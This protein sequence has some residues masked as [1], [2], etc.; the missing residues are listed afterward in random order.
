[1]KDDLNPGQLAGSRDAL[2]EALESLRSK[3]P[4][5]TGSRSTVTSSFKSP[6]SGPCPDLVYWF[7]LATGT[8][9]ANEKEAL[10][11]HASVCSACLAQL[12]QCQE[13]LSP[14]S[15]PEEWQEFKDFASATPQWQHRLAVELAR[16]PHQAQRSART[17]RIFAW[18]AAAVAAVLLI[19]AAVTVWWRQQNA[20]EKLLAEAYSKSRTFD[21]RI[22]G[23]GFAP[24]GDG[25]HL[26]GGSSGH[27]SASLLNARARIETGLEKN[28]SD[29]HWLQLQA[30]ADTLDE[31][32]DAAI[33]ILDRLIA[34]GPVTP[35]LL[36]DD[37][38]A[39]YLRGTATG[40][41]N[42]RATALDYLRR[43][44][45]LA[46]SDPVI[47]FNEALVMEDRGQVMNAVETWNR[48]LKFE[49]D[50][51]W[52]EEGRR[53]LKSLEDKLN[54]LKTHES[55]M[56]QHL[57][58]PQS[59]RAL[60]ADPA[61]LA[62]I[63]EELS[64]TLL[65]KLL[66]AAFPLPVDRS[67]GSPCD[68]Q[69]LA[70]R[71]LLRAL[72]SSLESHHQDSWLTQL[73]PP[74][75]SIT[76]D[77]FAQAAHALG[78]AIDAN[79][80]GDYH[81]AQDR[82]LESR[83]LFEKLGNSAGAARAEVE[84]IYSLERSGTFTACH[85]AVEALPSKYGLYVWIDTQA[86]TVDASCDM[87]PG[88]AAMNNPTIANAIHSAQKHQYALLELRATNILGAF[89]A[90]SGDSE[91]AWR[92]F[93]G[94]LRKFY[95]GDYPP[96]RAATA[97]AGLAAI[98][99]STPRVQLDLLVNRETVNLL[100]LARNGAI[101]VQQRNRLIRAAIRAGSL[102]EAR[103]QMALAQKEN[104]PDPI[105]Q[106]E[107]EILMADLLLDRGDPQSAAQ[108]LDAAHGH[109][110]GKDDDYHSKLYAAAR[111]E[112][113]L[114]QGHFEAAESTLRG[115]ILK[116]EL[117]ARGAG[118][119][120]VVFARQ[121]RDLYAALAGV[122]LA[123]GRPGIDI[124]ALWERYR[125]RILGESVPACTDG[126]LDCLAPEL[127]RA[128]E[129]ESS[130]G[131]M[132]VGQIAL[133]DR[134]LLY[135][136][137]A[138]NVVWKN[139]PLKQTELLAASASLER[140]TS[141]P[142]SSQA[143]VD[144]AAQRLGNML[145]SDLRSPS[146]SGS[147]LLL[148]PDPLLGNLPWPAVETSDGPI[149]LRFSLQE[150]PTILQSSHALS[151]IQGKPLVVGAS[152][153]AGDHEFLPE[154]PQEARTVA[155][156]EANSTM[157]V[158][159]DATEPKVAAHLSSAPLIHFAG[160]AMQF[161]GTTRLLLASSGTAGD[162]PWLD[163]SLLLKDPPRAARLVVFSACSTGKR[164]EGWNHGM[165]DIV[166]TLA[167]LGIPE[168]VATRWQID[169]ASAVPMMRA[170]Y[171]GLAGGLRVPQA[172]TAARNSLIRDARYSHPYYWAAYYAS[173]AGNTDLREVFH[174]DN[175]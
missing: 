48:Y 34:A 11:S 27:E 148:E 160:H 155:S 21:L 14:D 30:R 112:L 129:R 51:K 85:E 135:R 56:E 4:F 110:V 3:A 161:E 67:R 164:E 116:E 108:M 156:V 76:D 124:L 63:D 79:A 100:S 25:S 37:A 49:R 96:F 167:Y 61:T 2:T 147:V 50:P 163:R 171:G 165:G 125:L 83:G 119:E 20:P 104:V 47:L 82:S 16:T 35:G 126:R 94:I 72:A 101:R 6:D 137:E 159:G 23:A 133:R 38:S 9:E 140:V 118:Q 64:T 7:R 122:W 175:R 115:A 109:M 36:T 99:D 153:A 53:R 144:Q 90:D 41:E 145:F 158:A 62:G 98:E 43:A 105:L 57:A 42:D 10:L 84:R 55:R 121:D 12:R 149:G 136:A 106:A 68:E 91:T 134:V 174:G 157:L 141:T 81:P 1:M 22:P 78:Q 60:A 59:M 173:G 114:T 146:A 93:T 58:T 33:D 172:L 66:D 75:S 52:L 86:H 131:D 32:Y 73:L 130:F 151:G 166:D 89:A 123:Q 18:T 46:P 142:S 26:R 120:N 19:A 154:V 17:P 80:R 127:K 152:A 103:E 92:N 102:Q 107:G 169:S 87:S 88:T 65:P 132:L 74:G 44:D 117:E 8:T 39:Y 31:N 24:A 113:E 139:V 170:F 150:A 69:C 54:R 95:Q 29:P 15:S 128:L 13:A 70:A 111:G 143:S 77:R 162:K 28:P 168:V 71:S 5:G 40:S 97:M 138:R 45:E